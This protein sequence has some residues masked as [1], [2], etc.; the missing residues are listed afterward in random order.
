MTKIS[1][2]A[3]LL[4]L[5]FA[6]VIVLA[7]AP[8]SA[9][10]PCSHHEMWTG[11]PCKAGNCS[12]CGFCAYCCERYDIGCEYCYAFAAPTVTASAECDDASTPLSVDQFDRLFGSGDATQQVIAPVE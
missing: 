1:R 8:A 12:H 11:T 6:L 3:I 5:A 7:P 4:A 2:P 10:P 9:C